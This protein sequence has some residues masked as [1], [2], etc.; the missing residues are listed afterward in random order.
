[1]TK[2]VLPESM[3]LPAIAI[4]TGLRQMFPALPNAGAPV[5]TR[6]PDGAGLGAV[7]QSD[8]WSCHGDVGT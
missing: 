7:R 3:K 2:P 8:E 5:P 1:M 6:G 4:M